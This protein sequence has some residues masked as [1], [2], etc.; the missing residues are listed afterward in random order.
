MPQ[1]RPLPPAFSSHTER[2]TE[3]PRLLCHQGGETPQ[4]PI[5]PVVLQLVSLPLK[6]EKGQRARQRPSFCKQREIFPLPSLAQQ[7]GNGRKAAHISR[8]KVLGALQID[9]D[10]AAKLPVD[11]TPVLLRQIVRG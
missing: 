11:V 7:K 3:L 8:R 1:G 10:G 9:P 6:M 2:A 5:P 4:P